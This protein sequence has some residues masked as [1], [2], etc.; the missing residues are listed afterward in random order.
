MFWS[1][2]LLAD[3]TNNDI[4]LTETIF[5]GHTK[6]TLLLSYC[7]QFSNLRQAVH[8]VPISFAEGVY[9]RLSKESK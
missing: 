1:F 3:E 8:N 7:I 6:I 2:H 4:T 5:Q 9:Q